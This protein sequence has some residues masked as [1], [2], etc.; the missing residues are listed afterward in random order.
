MKINHLILTIIIMTNL[1][2]C[3]SKDN[4]ALQKK[5]TFAYDRAFIRKYDKSAFVL[6]SGESSILVSP[7]YQAKVFTST[8]AGDGGKSFGWIHYDAFG[9]A[10]DPHMNA[11]GGENRIWLGPEGG[12]FSLFFAPGIKMEFANW[13]TP[14]AYDSESW[15]VAFHSSSTV[16]LYKDMDLENY[17]GT[18]FDLRVYRL[19]SILKSAAIDSLLGLT[20]DSSVR[21]VGYETENTLKNTGR[22]AWTEQSGT[23]CIW[24]LDM[25]P[26]SAQTT[27]VVP[28]LSDLA[29]TKPAT[30]NYFGEIPDERIKTDGKT[31]FFKADGKMRGKLGIHPIRVKNIAG[32]YDAEHGVLTL[33]LFEKDN[34]GKYLNQE[35]NTEKEPFSGDAMNC[36]ND[37]PLADGTQMGPFYELESVAPAAFLKPGESQKHK[38]AVFHFTG[39]ENSLNQISLKTLGVG[40]AEIKDALK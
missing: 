26:P 33:I 35:W 25:F 39:S 11:Y 1:L 40:L 23:P 16:S 18:K 3:R 2:S 21:A 24:L 14:A 30:T 10:L 4:A 13:H 9:K 8:A 31:L 12:K 15:L 20:P 28:Y 17:A 22:E 37:G 6:T 36:Y 7:K 38:H 34:L 5:G 29:N 19:I 32:S 27:I